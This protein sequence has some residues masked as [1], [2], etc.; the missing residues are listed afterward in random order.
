MK[1]C[2]LIFKKKGNKE[3]LSKR[4]KSN[5]PLYKLNRSFLFIDNQTQYI[6]TAPVDY[7]F[8]S[9][10]IYKGT[11]SIGNTYSLI[12]FNSSRGKYISNGS[13]WLYI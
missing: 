10:I 8:D 4:A 11:Y 12:A 2:D 6:D 9:S 5:Y 1:K 7:F 13:L 3:P